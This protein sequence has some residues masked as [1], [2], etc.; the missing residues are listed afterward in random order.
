MTKTEVTILIKDQ[1]GFRAK[2]TTKDKDGHLMMI[3][4][5]LVHEDMSALN[6]HATNYS[7]SKKEKKRK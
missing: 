1:A 3:K 5:L 4:G 2:K 6:I 7:T